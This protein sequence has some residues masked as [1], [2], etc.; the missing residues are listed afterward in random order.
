MKPFRIPIFCCLCWLIAAGCG[1]KK[2]L[3]F[4]GKTMGSTYQVKVVAGYFQSAGD[5]AQAIERRL[6][7]INQHLSIYRKDSEISRFNRHAASDPFPVS[8]MFAEILEISRPLYELTGGAWDPTVAPLVEL[9]GFGAGEPTGRIPPRAAIEQ[10]M[11]AV[12]FHRLEFK[13]R[14]FI[15]EQPGLSLDLG[16]VAQGFGA[17]QVAKVIEAAGFRDYL[18]EIGGEVIASGVRRDGTDWR[19]GINTPVQGSPFDKVYKIVTLRNHALATSGDYRN[20]FVVD[21]KT[22]SHIID[23]RTGYPIAN[24]VVSVSILAKSCTFADGLATA[25]M[26][27]GRK[28]GLALIRN[29]P[30]VEGM[31]VERDPDGRLTDYYSE[32]FRPVPENKA[33]TN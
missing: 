32:G 33:I 3:V 22:Y 10:R 29:L 15:K 14:A 2:E 9:W 25:L 18:V 5:L 26:V 21:G 20:F 7:E 19:I 1:L 16:S 11:A 12:G 13:D 23:P 30:D 24:G 8:D 6:A 28:E 17:D 31:I 27:M 4:S